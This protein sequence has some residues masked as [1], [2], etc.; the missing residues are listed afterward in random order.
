MRGAVDVPALLCL[1][2]DTRRM[3]REALASQGRVI[4][5]LILREARTRYGRHKLGYLWALIEPFLHIGMFMLLF[6]YMG[7][8][9]ALGDSIPMFLATG[10]ATYIGFRNVLNRTRG[11]YN[12]NQGLL[13]FPPVKVMDVFVGR[14]LLELATWITVTSI[15]MTVLI[16]FGHGGAP[17]SIPMMLMAIFALFAIG[18]GVGTFIGILGEFVPSLANVLGIPLRLLY[19]MSGIFY[20]PEAMAPAFRDILIW[21]PVVHG[22]T[23]FR[24]GYYEYYDS[25]AFDANYLLI[26]SIAAVFIALVAERVA[27]KPLRAL[28]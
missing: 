2:D 7:R 1:R 28:S 4:L 22:I 21:N 12:S 20:L 6:S 14:A 17:R 23:L 15:L 18:F 11:G 26:W 3:F 27:R 13:A 25:F 8:H 19:L 10:F 5:A 9:V 16:A 24:M